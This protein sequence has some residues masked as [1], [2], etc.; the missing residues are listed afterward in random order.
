MLGRSHTGANGG[1]S[2]WI[3]G[4]GSGVIDDKA[5]LDDWYVVALGNKIV[6]GQATGARLLEHDLVL[7]RAVDGSL[8]AWDDRCPHRGTRLSLGEVRGDH[9]VCAYH[10]WNFAGD[11]RCDYLPAHPKQTPPKQACVRTYSVEER[12]GL[13]FVTLGEPTDSV[14]AFEELTDPAYRLVHCGPYEVAAAAPRIVENFLDMAHFPFVHK[15]YLGQEPQT[16]VPG[17]KVEMR[18][19]GVFAADCRFWQPNPDPKYSGG[20]MMSYDFGIVRPLVCYL[21]K[22]PEEG[23]HRDFILQ[24]VTP[25][26][27]FRCDIWMIFARAHHLYE[28]DSTYQD[29]ENLI[30]AQDKVIL[31]SQR[32]AAL[33]LDL[34]AEVHQRCDALAVAYRRWLRQK[35]VRY[36]TSDA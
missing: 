1:V 31:E 10:G 9:L 13:V 29:F 24:A 25:K 36:G 15:G 23:A 34:T 12:H 7:W 2:A 32:P 21:A 35:G 30:V 11:G 17:Y 16:E 22:D 6:R 33:P 14:I 27:E 4:T 8:H 28:P 20:A 18:E 5:T 26:D 3:D 19:D